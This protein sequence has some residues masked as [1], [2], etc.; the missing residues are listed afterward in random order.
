MIEIKENHKKFSNKHIENLEE[1][2]MSDDYTE[3]LLSIDD[4]IVGCIEEDDEINKVGVEL[5]KIYNEVYLA[6]HS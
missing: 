3:L 6:K 2:L 5:Q 4:A 1:L